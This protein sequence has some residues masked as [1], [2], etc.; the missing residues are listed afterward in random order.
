MKIVEVFLV[1]SADVPHG[2]W[3]LSRVVEEV[4]GDDHYFFVT[5]FGKSFCER[6]LKMIIEFFQMHTRIPVN[7]A[8]YN[9]F[10]CFLGNSNENGL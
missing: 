10:Q 5:F 9:I 6:L 4:E 1:I 8:N 7:V 3:S 2:Q